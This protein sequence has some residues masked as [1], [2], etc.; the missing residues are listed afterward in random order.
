MWLPALAGRIGQLRL[1]FRLKAVNF[2]LK[3]EA[4]RIKNAF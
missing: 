1:N 4:T 3:A 2:R